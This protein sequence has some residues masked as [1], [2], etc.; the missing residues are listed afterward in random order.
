MYRIASKMHEL[1]GEACIHASDFV[2]PEYLED[3]SDVLICDPARFPA[4]PCAGL[5]LT[6]LLLVTSFIR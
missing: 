2:P 6:S 4:N 3:E 1:I 5:W